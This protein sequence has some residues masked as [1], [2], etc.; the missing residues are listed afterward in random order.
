MYKK[1]KQYNKHLNSATILG[2]STS[3]KE[4]GKYA[5]ICDNTEF[6][7]CLNNYL[8]TLNGL[9]TSTL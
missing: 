3:R 1:S 4:L 6:R 7:I 9:T 8:L 2:G 5:Y